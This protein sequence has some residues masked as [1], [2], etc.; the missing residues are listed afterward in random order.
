MFVAYFCVNCDLFPILCISDLLNCFHLAPRTQFLLQMNTT[1][2]MWGPLFIIVII[3][4]DSPK[5]LDSE[6]ASINLS[7]LKLS[8]LHTRNWN[9]SFHIHQIF[10]ILPMNNWNWC[11]AAVGPIAELI[12]CPQFYTRFHMWTCLQYS[13]LHESLKMPY[14]MFYLQHPH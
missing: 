7:K 10:G 9:F 12:E 11:Q 1:M 13:F 14:L 5:M 2:K 4:R 8:L 3:C 6:N